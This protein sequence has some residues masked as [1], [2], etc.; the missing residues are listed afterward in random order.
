M[1]ADQSAQRL[2]RRDL[3]VAAA[4]LGRV[5]PFA[6]FAHLS[7]QQRLCDRDRLGAAHREDQALL[8]DLDP[9]LGRDRS[10]DIACSLGQTPAVA[11][12][13][14]GDGDEAEVADRG[15]IGAGVAVEHHHPLA[16]HGRRQSM[17][18]ADDPRADDGDAEGRL[19]NASH[20]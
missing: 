3:A 7:G 4:Q 8:F 18:Q 13:L 15:A 12:L 11:A 5:Q 20:R 19:L 2:R 10:P 14:A 17:G 9:G 16:R 6:A 1:G